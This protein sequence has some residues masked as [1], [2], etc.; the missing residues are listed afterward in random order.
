MER[1]RLKDL[2]DFV[3]RTIREGYA[4]KVLPYPVFEGAEAH[5]MSFIEAIRVQRNDAVH[6]M[7]A[8]V[9]ADSARLSYYAF[10]HALEKIEALR[11]WFLANPKSI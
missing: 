8:T 9:S 3:A 7:N 1:R 4:S 11:A 5:L 2:F 6:P 10:P